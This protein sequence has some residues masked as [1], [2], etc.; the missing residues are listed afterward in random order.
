MPRRPTQGCRPGALLLHL[1][2]HFP[3]WDLP[4]RGS[5]VSPLW[6]GVN[7]RP[8]LLFLTGAQPW[9][10]TEPAG[11]ESQ[12][13]APDCSG[14]LNIPGSFSESWDNDLLVMSS[15]SSDFEH[16]LC[17]LCSF[18]LGPPLPAG[19]G[20]TS[21]EP[22]QLASCLPSRDPAGRVVLLVDSGL[23]KNSN[24]QST[25]SITYVQGPLLI[26]CEELMHGEPSSWHMISPP[27]R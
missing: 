21:R 16:W 9:P 14:A 8:S 5:F 19:Q 23:S 17:S 4:P 3:L 7:G 27:K 24:V 1:L 22:Q 26:G 15:L 6:D 20:S 2:T 11:E 10:H 13:A 12:R 18:S 25:T